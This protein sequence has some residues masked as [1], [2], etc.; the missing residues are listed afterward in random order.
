MKELVVDIFHLKSQFASFWTQSISG[1]QCT[2]MFSNIAK[3]VT[4]ISKQGI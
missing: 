3:L 1:Q 4:I 2:N